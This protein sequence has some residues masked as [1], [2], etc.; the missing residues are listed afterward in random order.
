MFVQ[1]C[2]T[3][4][5]QK[6]VDNG[7]TELQH[8]IVFSRLRTLWRNRQ[9]DQMAQGIKLLT[10]IYKMPVSY[11]VFDTTYLNSPV[12]YFPLAEYEDV[13]LK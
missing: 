6:L 11:L 10:C 9:P 3:L 12:F 5:V 2:K 7:F 8:Y 13:P 1:I 4:N